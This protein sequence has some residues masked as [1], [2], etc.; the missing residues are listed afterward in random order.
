MTDT[1]DTHTVSL[2]PAGPDADPATWYVR[3]IN[4]WGFGRLAVWLGQ[5]ADLPGAERVSIACH[6]TPSCL[7]VTDE[8]IANPDSYDIYIEGVAQALTAAFDTPTRTEDTARMLRATGESKASLAAANPLAYGGT[9]RSIL[10]RCAALVAIYEM[11][12]PQQ[13]AAAV[14]LVTHSDIADIAMLRTTAAAATC[15][16][17]S[18]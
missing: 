14:A 13:R 1:A 9:W 12:D 3:D 18:A 15:R 16:P 2:N 5:G 11:A 10:N 4:I 6:I 8:H 7:A 17:E